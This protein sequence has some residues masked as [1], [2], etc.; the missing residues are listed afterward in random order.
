MQKEYQ[1]V[2]QGKVF[3]IKFSANALAKLER[4]RG[5]GVSMFMNAPL[6]GQFPMNHLIG[7]F[8]AGVL[9]Y[10]PGFTEEAAGK[11]IEPSELGENELLGLV[12]A[13]RNAWFAFIG[14]DPEE[15][16]KKILKE[17]TP[18]EDKPKKSKAG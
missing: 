9:H 18:T 2:L 4:Y 6:A 13:I 3:R 1:A 15:L 7:A 14:V 11:I 16:E 17:A 12:E 5:D 10:M 8:W